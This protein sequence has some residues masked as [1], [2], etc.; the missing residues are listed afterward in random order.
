MDPN[1]Y[2]P[3]LSDTRSPSPLDRSTGRG[4]RILR[5]HAHGAFLGLGYVYL[6]ATD[7][8]A[9]LVLDIVI[10]VVGLAGLFAFTYRKPFLRARFWLLWAVLLPT[11]DLLF[12]FLFYL[13]DGPSTGPVTKALSLLPVIPEYVALGLYASSRSLWVPANQALQPD[14]HLGRSAPSAAAAECHV[15]VSRTER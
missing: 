13:P 1:P 8:R 9:V 15:S 4:W 12:N 6:I 14:D 2:A 10:S 11:W 7:L 5:V 3:P